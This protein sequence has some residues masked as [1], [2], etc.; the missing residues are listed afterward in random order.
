MIAKIDTVGHFLNDQGTKWDGI[1]ILYHKH[2]C[3]Q[4]ERYWQNKNME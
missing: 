1:S 3:K 2:W 4:N